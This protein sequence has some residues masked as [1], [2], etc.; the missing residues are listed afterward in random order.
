[1]DKLVRAF[2]AHIQQMPIGRWRQAMWS[3]PDL[4]VANNLQRSRVDD[5]QVVPLGVSDVDLRTAVW[6]GPRHGQQQT[7]SNH[8]DQL[9]QFFNSFPTRLH[10]RPGVVRSKRAAIRL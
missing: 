5:G 4:D 7:K 2:Y 9:C 8:C 3:V 1:G 10:D 6:Q